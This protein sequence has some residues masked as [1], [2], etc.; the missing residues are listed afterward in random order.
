V[1]LHYL[2]GPAPDAGPASEPGELFYEGQRS[3]DA[4]QVLAE[5]Q[6]MGARTAA[7]ECDLSDPAAAALLFDR[8]EEAL[9]SVDVLVNNAA[10]WEADTL[11]PPDAELANPNV[12]MWTD[13]PR[14]LDAG[15][16]D[17]IFAVNAR[18]VALLMAEFARRHLS[19]DAAWGRI[20]N[21]STDGAYVFP[22]EVSYG[23]SKLALEGLSRSA[24]T[25]YA[26]AGIT[27]NVVSPGPTQTGWISPELEAHLL[28]TIPLGRMG[29]PEDVS[30]VIVFLASEQARWLTGQTLH[31]GG[32]HRM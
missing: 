23:A 16:F 18:A 26:S 13:R 14:T 1:F 11:L 32:G 29:T 25:E 19:R 21:V 28:P 10:Y 27:V 31:A 6:A 5:L 3:L 12:E 30:D 17:R 7:W 22:S 2:R 15:S 20:I 4:G 8:A 9:G 24:A